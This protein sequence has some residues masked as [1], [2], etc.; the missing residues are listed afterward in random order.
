MNEVSKLEKVMRHV[1]IAFALFILGALTGMMLTIT[2][3][4]SGMRVSIP[5]LEVNWTSWSDNYDL[6]LDIAQDSKSR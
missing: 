5:R 6:G 3:L 1:S 2:A 4:N